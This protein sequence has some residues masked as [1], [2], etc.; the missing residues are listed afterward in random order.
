MVNVLDASLGV[1]IFYA[2]HFL[3][4]AYAIVGKRNSFEFLID[5]VVLGLVERARN[6]GKSCVQIACR[7]GIAGDDERRSSLIDENRVYLVDDGVVVIALSEIVPVV[8]QVV[9]QIIEAEL[10]VGAVCNVRLIRFLLG[11]RAEE[12]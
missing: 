9:S 4:L 8:D 2:K 11:R 10:V 6:L 7:A 3:R 1:N 12:F 5:R